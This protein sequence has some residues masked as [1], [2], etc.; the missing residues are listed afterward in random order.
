MKQVKLLNQRIIFCHLLNLSV[1]PTYLNFAGRHLWHFREH[2]KQNIP[3]SPSFLV[4]PGWFS[5]LW[6]EIPIS[7]SRGISA[8]GLT[9]S[10]PLKIHSSCC[11]LQQALQGW[12]GGEGYVNSPAGLDLQE[13]ESPWAPFHCWGAH[14]PT[15]SS[16]QLLSV[17]QLNKTQ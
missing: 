5:P 2:E 9:C 17:V 14:T 8:Q 13:S 11:F 16:G 10:V 12:F 6:N 1:L 7:F 15:G 3:N 4:R